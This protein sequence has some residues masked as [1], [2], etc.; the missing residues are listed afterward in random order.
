MA[1]KNHQARNEARAE[2][3]TVSVGP[4]ALNTGC[5]SAVGFEAKCDYAFAKL[6]VTYIEGTRS[7]GCP[8]NRTRDN[9]RHRGVPFLAS[10]I[11]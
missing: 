1:C 11:S 3:S 10:I 5:L 6:V 8:R 4:A 9:G 7:K 2:T